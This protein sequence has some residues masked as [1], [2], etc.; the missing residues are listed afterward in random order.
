MET[1]VHVITDKTK[2]LIFCRGKCLYFVIMMLLW[3]MS[4]NL[5]TWFF[6]SRSGSFIKAKKHLCE[7]ARKAMYGVIRKMSQIDFVIRLWL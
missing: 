1:T 7:Q 6:F 4:K 5:D 3:K 2:I